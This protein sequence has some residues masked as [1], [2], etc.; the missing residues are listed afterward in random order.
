MAG[1][2]G[3]T[4]WVGTVLSARDPVALAGFYS[5]LL[6]WEI[7]RESPE[8][9]TIRMPDSTHY[10]AFAVDDGTPWGRLTR[11]VT[12]LARFLDEHVPCSDHKTW[13]W[14]ERRSPPPGP[15]PTKYVSRLSTT[16]HT[17]PARGAGG[18]S[19][20]GEVAQRPP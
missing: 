17:S 4:G 12:A 6:G 11:P 2:S 5:T 15:A 9:V 7:T 1:I 20:R 13:P 8:W 19:A 10:L 16:R 18:P 14:S 3:L